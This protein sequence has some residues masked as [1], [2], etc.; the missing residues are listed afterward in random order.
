MSS[1]GYKH[2]EE[3]VVDDDVDEQ[4]DIDTP[5]HGATSRGTTN[6]SS[7]NN[8][9]SNNN[10]NSNIT[11]LLNRLGHNNGATAV[12]G[13]KQQKEFQMEHL[14]K[15]YNDDN[16][17]EENAEN[18]NNDN[19]DYDEEDDERYS[20]ANDMLL[21]NEEQ[22]FKTNYSATRCLRRLFI[23]LQPQFW[24]YMFGF[25]ALSI[26]TLCQLLLP[27]YFALQIENTMDQVVINKIFLDNPNLNKTQMLESFGLSLDENFNWFDSSKYLLL[28]IAVQVPFAFVRYIMFTIA[29]FNFVTHLK[30]DL[31][32]AVL[33]QEVTYFDQGKGNEL[34]AIITSDTLVLQN[35]VSVALSTF[36]R[37]ILQCGGSILILVFLSWRVT[38]Y[39]YIQELQNRASQIVDMTT[40]NITEIRLLNAE[41]KQLRSFETELESTHRAC[42]SSVFTTGFWIA[43][44]SVLVFL[45]MVAGF[46][47]TLS[48]TVH[49]TIYLFQY[50]L[51]ALMLSVSVSGMFGII[52]E[53]QKLLPSCRRIFSL[54]D[55]RPNVAFS[56]GVP[57]S[58]NDTNIAFDS[59]SFHHK[60]GSTLLSNISFKVPKGKMVSVVGLST[61]A[62]DMLFALI[63]GIHYPTK[64]SLM[65]GKVDTRA[66]DLHSFRAICYSITSNTVIFDG[67]VEQ[68]IRYG[69]NHLSQQNIIEASKKAKLHDF[70]ISL[71][72]G[73]DTMLGK[74]RILGTV[75]IQKISL[76][77]AYLR[78]PAVLLVD[79]SSCINETA[80]DLVTPLE[81]LM[82]NRTVLIVA[83]RLTTL[84]KSHHVVVFDDSHVANVGSHSELSQQSTT[85]YK[86]IRMSDCLTVHVT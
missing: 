27:Y 56:S 11:N 29:S 3:D 25:L 63:Q 77:R 83:N 41:S 43:V 23:Y 49:R 68:N 52:G 75:H 21:D 2:L 85:L 57:A 59:V 86:N 69:L 19:N 4:V 65:I 73:Y 66:L 78:D 50:V 38:L 80:E 71:P 58:N 7:S 1:K 14:N 34:N 74:E 6:L 48:E 18:I 10:S 70:I 62:K 28:I 81:Q 26:T 31:F 32:R 46:L 16:D 72:Q 44:G 55:R 79:E 13:G 22:F 53:F 42:K 40:T 36:S 82:K 33:M 64:G 84:E 60:S 17:E 39:K 8:N 54:I 24:F 35:I 67:T 30:N 51:Y 9:N 20:R 37:S 47:F 45:L 61:Q 15:R 5:G 12:G 76:A